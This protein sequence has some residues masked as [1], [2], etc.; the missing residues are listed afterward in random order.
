M[1]LLYEKKFLSSTIIFEKNIL[2]ILI[3][4]YFLLSPFFSFLK[5]FGIKKEN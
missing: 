2:T 5:R 1:F 3:V 4:P